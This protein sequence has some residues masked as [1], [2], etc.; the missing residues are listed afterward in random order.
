MLRHSRKHE[1]TWSLLT[2]T[3][4]LKAFQPFTVYTRFLGYKMVLRTTVGLGDRKFR[5]PILPITAERGAGGHI[6]G[7]WQR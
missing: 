5:V 1:H 4:Q 3:P 6:V 7:S 2:F